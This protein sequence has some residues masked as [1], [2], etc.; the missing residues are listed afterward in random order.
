MSSCAC[1]ACETL[2]DPV[3]TLV[4]RDMAAATHAQFWARRFAEI[5]GFGVRQQWEIAIAVTE[6]ASNVVKFAREGAISLRWCDEDHVLEI[7]AVD[8]GPG[9]ADPELSAQDGVTGGVRRREAASPASCRGLGLG[10]GAVRRLT[11]SVQVAPR[12]AGGLRV[13]ARKHRC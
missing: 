6:L 5:C 3:V 10:L 4:V 13:L 11:D 12:P 2:T 1:S 8:Q 9:M 7:E